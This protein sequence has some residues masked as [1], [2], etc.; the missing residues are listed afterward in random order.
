RQYSH[1]HRAAALLAAY[2]AC[3]A[4]WRPDRDDRVLHCTGLTHSPGTGSR[5][6][7]PGQT[8]RAGTPTAQ[9][10]GQASGTADA[11]Q[12]YPGTP[13][14]GAYRDPAGD[15]ASVVQRQPAAGRAEPPRRAHRPVQPP[16]TER[17]T[18]SRLCPR[19][20]QPAAA[21]DPDDGPGSLQ[22]GQ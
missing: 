12:R 5:A 6:P 17:G 3:P 14:T 7:G 18:G 20:T 16:D 10:T 2:A 1:R 11:D 19:G 4:D 15:P 13:C 9:R 8:D 22:A 21:G